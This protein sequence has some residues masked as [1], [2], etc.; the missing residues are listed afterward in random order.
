MGD[1]PHQPT[2]PA[3]P[4]AAQAQAPMRRATLS[5]LLVITLLDLLGI[6]LLIPVI[7]YLVKQF[8]DNAAVAG[9]LSATYALL[10]FLA[11]PVL[12][13][14]SDRVGRRPV[15]IVSLIGSAIG[16]AIFGLAGALWMLFV[17]RA[18]DGIT[19]GNIS[20]AYAYAADVSTPAERG[21]TFGMMGA[22]MG[23]G[24]IIG[25]GIGGWLASYDFHYP[26]FAAAGAALLS[27]AWG[28]FALPES[29]TPERREKGPMQLSLLNPL[30]TV[31]GKFVGG[32]FLPVM[33]AV[34]AVSFTQ[35]SMYGVF[36]FWTHD[37]LDWGPSEV[38]Y[39]LV[40]AGIIGVVVQGGL[41][42]VLSKKIGDRATLALGLLTL[43][44][45]CA[46]LGFSTQAW[47][48]YACLA[49]W[50]I[51]GGLAGASSTAMVSKL[52]GVHEQGQAMG[53]SQA[54]AGLMRI[55]GPLWGGFAYDH[56]GAAVQYLVPGTLTLVVFVMLLPR[57]ARA[58]SPRT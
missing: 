12:G 27:A 23:L 31:S 54:L 4:V 6:G 2:E 13:A 7:P 5:L 24:F 51:G 20:T 44:L 52:A 50:S 32:A 14:L 19:G 46:V 16:Y 55:A 56:L 1:A 41:V 45:A 37:M 25:P 35:A 10:Q 17:G 26:A 22:A 49:V 36:A 58:S 53:V 43:G 3:G 9:V 39:I 21:K 29:L 33:L 11:T 47:M 40:M 15:L 38:S 8:T 42:R 34:V 18:I 57:V 28:F 48:L 30:R